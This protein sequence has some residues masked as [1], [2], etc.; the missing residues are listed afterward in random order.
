MKSTGSSRRGLHLAALLA[1][2]A[3]FA[4]GIA[5]CGS[6]GSSESSASA[7][8][9]SGQ[10]G[11]Q[12]QR[13]PSTP[14]DNTFQRVSCPV[15]AKKHFARVRIIGHG[16]VALALGYRYIV[17]PWRNG[18]FAKGAT[19]RKAAFFKAAFFGAFAYHELRVSRKILLG[20]TKLCNKYEG[21][22]NRVGSKVTALVNKVRSHKAVT[23]TELASSSS[24]L[25]ALERL[26]IKPAKHLPSLG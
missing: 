22:M 7:S 26:G 19:G 15:N 1:V 24:A 25:D 16:A 5:A 14:L 4:T 20:D 3:L 10:S 9:G 6:S 18:R 21:V 11:S 12:A 8:T 23:E 2:L 13:L 17:K